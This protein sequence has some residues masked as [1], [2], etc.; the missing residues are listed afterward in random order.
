[1][2]TVL[3]R[4]S[5][6][7]PVTLGKQIASSGEGEV[8]ETNFSGILAK[9]YHNSTPERIEK[10]KAMLANPPVD[11]MAS[12]NHI[13]IAFPQDLLKDGNGAYVGF[14]MSAVR[15]SRELTTVYNPSLRKK[16]APGFNWYYLHVT[17]LNTA[18]II[19]ALHEKGYVLGDI[20]PQNIL[21]NDRAL[22]AVIDTD[23]FQVR[24]DKIGK[25]YRCTV[26]SE[27]FTPVE[28]LGKDFSTTDQTEICDRFRLGVLIHYLLFG[29]HPFSG[30]WTG[31]SDSPEQTELI[32]KGY[33][34]GGQNSLIRPSQNTIPLDVVHPEI[35]RCFLKC[36]NDGHALPHL[37]PTAEDW[38]NAL[39]VAVNQLTACSNVNNHIYSQ[40]Y[41]KCY[42]CERVAKLGVDIFPFVASISPTVIKTTTTQSTV[43]Q[44]VPSSTLV[45]QASK[46]SVSQS[47]SNSPF[48]TLPPQQ[49]P[50]NTNTGSSDWQKA[51]ITSSVIGTFLLIGLLLTRQQPLPTQSLSQQSVAQQ[52]ISP[53]PD[54]SSSPNTSS[55]VEP[56][57]ESSEESTASSDSTSAPTNSSI[58]QS[59]RQFSR[60][61]F[62]KASCGDPLPSNSSNYPINFYP[63]FVP[64]TNENLANIRSHFCQ[65]SLEKRRKDSGKLA[66]QV[67]SFTSKDTAMEFVEF[68]SSEFEGADVGEPTVIVASSNL[69]S[70]S[71]FSI[72]RRDAVA[73]IDKW[74]AYK[75]RIF[76]S[77]Y[78]RYLGDEILTGKAYNDKIKRS[79][80][81][82]SSSEWLANRGAYYSYGV[83]S[84]DSVENFA[85]NGDRATIDIVVTEQR[86]LYSS[87]GKIDR[88]ASGFDT[89]LVRYNLQSDNGQWKIADFYT[90]KTILKR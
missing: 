29:Y 19:Q 82:E 37:R 8:W 87:N 66:V 76:A 50:P 10:L 65:D 44:T 1:M 85:V 25:I 4:A 18:W 80:G 26:G 55:S 79:D 41:G 5:N 63:V 12:Q 54:T 40:H 89:R 83:Q 20:K 88:N 13:S 59:E 31:A 77:P 45:N 90:V 46:S 42:W 84:I 11:P 51:V 74:Q 72:S 16:K 61:D 78:E 24:D 6:N 7:Q 3:T 71:S 22:V 17:A 38:R 70:P 35:R 30:E 43:I 14:L 58:L 23:S 32:R 36:F 2:M 34:Y 67:A 81:Q 53:M 49:S 48:T 27:G 15:V 56:R 62:P 64:F 73:L 39:Q 21:V 86:T 52:D 47:L 60:S 69:Y 68:I 28:L 9:I 75:R 57:R 33:W